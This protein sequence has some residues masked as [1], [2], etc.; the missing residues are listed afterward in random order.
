MTRENR[1]VVVAYVVCRA[2]AHLAQLSCHLSSVAGGGEQDKTEGT[3]GYG[4]SGKPATTGWD[5][6]R[7][8]RAWIVLMKRL[9]YTRFV[10][11]S[12]R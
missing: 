10:D 7:I 8:A 3:R 2:S 12:A 9:G 1:L 5:P 6:I 4:F 11:Q